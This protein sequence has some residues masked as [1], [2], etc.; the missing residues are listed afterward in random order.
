VSDRVSI[1]E[2]DAAGLA[3]CAKIKV[4]AVCNSPQ[5]IPPPGKLE[6]EVRRCECV[7]CKLLSALYY[8][9]AEGGT[10]IVISRTLS[11]A[12]DPGTPPR[13]FWA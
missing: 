4:S 2:F 12:P 3:M 13:T 11:R 5:L 9:F 6:L 1:R 10:C 7:V 8:K